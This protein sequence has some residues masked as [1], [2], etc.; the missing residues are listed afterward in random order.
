MCECFRVVSV[1]V[2][3]LVRKFVYVSACDCLSVCD[4]HCMCVFAYVC[5]CLR[6]YV[7]A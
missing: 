4:V 2:S 1:C 6:I 7:R 3:M 5:A